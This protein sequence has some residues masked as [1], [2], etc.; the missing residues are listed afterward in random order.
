MAHKDA[1]LLK[2]RVDKLM[3][4][5]LE[6]DEEFIETMNYVT[7]LI[8]EH[9]IDERSL[10]LA[11]QDRELQ[12]NRKFLENFGKMNDSVQEFVEKIENMNK[13]C[14]ELTSRIQT[15]KEKTKDLL[16]KTA[17]LQQEKKQLVTERNYIDD[18]FNKYS[19]TNNEEMIMGSAINEGIISDSFF[20]VL[21]KLSAIQQNISSALTVDPDSTALQEMKRQVEEK[22]EA[23]FSALFSFAQRECRLLNVEFLELKPILH[24]A[25]EALQ[26]REKLFEVVLE[27]YS[28]ARRSFVVR[29]Y[30]DVLTKGKGLSKPI[31]HLSG[32][33]L[34]YASDMLV[35]IHQALEGEVELLQ[36]L[37]RSCPTE[38]ITPTS[39][40]T[41]A[42]IS[43]ALCQPLKLRIEQNL[44]RETNSVVLYRLSSLFLY[45]SRHFEYSTS[46]ES[47]LVRTLKGLYELASNMF[48]S[49]V[50]STVQKILSNVP[51][52][53]YDLL[54]VNAINQTLFLLR[55]ILESQNDGAFTAIVDKKETYAR[56]FNHVLD[57][58]NQSIQL[59]CSNMHNPLD[60]AVY[61]LNCLNAIRTVIIMYQYTDNKLEMI[62]AQIEANEDVLVSE[63]ASTVF[64][65]CS[66]LDIYTKCVAHQQNQGPLAHI[67][68][69]EPDRI[70]D[71]LVQFD[72][73][74]AK[75]EGYQA[76]QMVKIS[77]ARSRETV[78]KRTAEHIVTAYKIIH[79]KIVD[80][81][82]LYP[83]LGVKSVEEVS[84][85]LLPQSP[86]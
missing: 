27:E 63:Q 71:S 51:V 74:L 86:Q 11:L 82:N 24:M 4:S 79:D 80:P 34:R 46:V 69:M 60:V 53:D 83:D 22:D 67:Q 40:K 7:D 77:S 73:F 13:I 50:G 75:P 33:P 48:Y 45:Y 44:S 76:H 66:M 20:K 30:I 62:K 37:L 59:V 28:A 81:S 6:E 5:K 15:N 18:F 65:K 52:P 38:V 57:P 21:R 10:K 35:W 36:A 14:T 78:Q 29:A 54:P 55:D 9:N 41:L 47:M 16:T 12:M 42:S 58:L 64:I 84:N 85:I 17:A 61:M 2:K 43:E 19:L 39:K 1:A 26:P 72:Q 3:V 8:S 49:V 68:G 25:V 23:A 32:D 31:E 56:I 70:K